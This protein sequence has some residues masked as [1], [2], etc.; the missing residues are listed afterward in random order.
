MEFVRAGRWTKF[1]RVCPTELK[2]GSSNQNTTPGSVPMWTKVVSVCG[3]MKTKFERMHQTELDFGSNNQNATPGPVSTGTKTEFVCGCRWVQP[4]EMRQTKL[5][6][7]CNNQTTTPDQCQHGPSWLLPV[8]VSLHVG[9]SSSIKWASLP[10][11]DNPSYVAFVSSSLFS[12][13]IACS[14]QTSILAEVPLNKSAVAN[15]WYFLVL[16]RRNQ[17]RFPWYIKTIRIYIQGFAVLS[18]QRRL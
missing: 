15:L 17:K 11:V 5:E 16:Y 7:G 9:P 13:A 3:R 4:N 10:C 1:D 12:V 8:L 18:L 14:V 2:F 6:F